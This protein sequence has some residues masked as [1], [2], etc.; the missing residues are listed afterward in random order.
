MD[1]LG[2]YQDAVVQAVAPLAPERV[3][4]SLASG[5]RLAEPVHALRPAPP[6][7]C[8]AMDGFAVRA[9]DVTGPARLQVVRAIFAGDLPGAPLGP[10]QAARIYT[11]APL[12]PGADA[13]VREEAAREE[14]AW[15]SFR[16]PVREGEHVRP[17]GE[18]VPAGGLALEA[19]ARLGPRQLGLC[20]AVG[21]QEVV[22]VR[23][24]R[25]VVLATGDEVVR[26]RTPD[27][28]GPVLEAALAALGAEVELRRVP[29]DLDALTG[30]LRGALAAADAVLTVGGVSVGARDHVRAAL[31]RLG[32]E[33]RVHG[34]PM[35]P[36]KPFL[37]ALSGGKPVFGL[38]GSPS[39]CLVAFE[40]FVRPA[41]LRLAG[42]AR[43][44]RRRLELRLAAPLRGKPGRA[45]L[46]WARLDDDGRVRPIGRDAAQIRGP[47]LADALVVA[48]SEAGELAE[49]T[50]VETWLLEEG[51]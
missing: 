31:E 35:K 8:S 42:A 18:D 40:V 27:S 45:R 32:A 23:R 19:G 7:T 25:A 48:P 38:P 13:V 22:A 39:A 6:L 10:G 21:V 17:Q 47:A 4:L 2:R 29:D 1:K 16:A 49:G 11:G 14:G 5:R 41:L 30:E 34:V 50:P 3:R 24:P 20:V 15:V 26:G 46:I 28:N 51:R 33:V 43:P 36:G 12:P 44:F 37:F 9:A